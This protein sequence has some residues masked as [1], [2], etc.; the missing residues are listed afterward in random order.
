MSTKQLLETFLFVY[1]SDYLLFIN[2]LIDVFIT[3][4]SPRVVLL[5]DLVPSNN[6][7]FVPVLFPLYIYMK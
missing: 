4:L 1:F 5:K 6:E 2:L 7:G 3:E